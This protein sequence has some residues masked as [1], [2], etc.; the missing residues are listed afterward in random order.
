[1]KT[2]KIYKTI[3]TGSELIGEFTTQEY[4]AFMK[5]AELFMRNMSDLYTHLVCIRGVWTVSLWDEKR[6]ETVL[7]YQAEFIIK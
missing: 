2:M 3:G 7:T 4:K 5:N 6:H 1:M